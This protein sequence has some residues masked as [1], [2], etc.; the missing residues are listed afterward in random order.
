ML[1]GDADIEQALRESFAE[2]IEP[3][4][5]R[6]RRRHRDDAII[7]TRFLHQAFGEHLGVG[8]RIGGALACAPVMTSNLLTP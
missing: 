5:V 3:G 8:R 4:A 1:L 7:Y 6:H 2:Q